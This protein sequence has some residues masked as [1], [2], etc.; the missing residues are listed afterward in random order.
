MPLYSGDLI[1]GPSNL[2]LLGCVGMG[3]VYFTQRPRMPL[4]ASQELSTGV[5][6]D[7]AHCRCLVRETDPAAVLGRLKVVRVSDRG[8]FQLSKVRTGRAL[9][10]RKSCDVCWHL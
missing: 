8:E 6:A 1:A 3:E 10:E 7:D 4:S 9:A 2:R 5:C